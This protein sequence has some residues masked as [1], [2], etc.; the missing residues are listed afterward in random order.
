MR[1]FVGLCL[2]ITGLSIGAY[3]HYPGPAHREASLVELTEIVTGAIHS[4]SEQ[5]ALDRAAGA[6]TLD[7]ATLQ[8]AIAKPR[9]KKSNRIARF[10]NSKLLTADLA[11]KTSAAEQ[12]KL[13][14]PATRVKATQAAKQRVIAIKEPPKL[15]RARTASPVLATGWRTAV[16]R[17]ETAPVK[18]GKRTTTLTPKTYAERWKLAK[19]LQSE[20]KRVGCYWGK[21]DGVWGKGS[22]WAIADF[23]RSVN[24]TLP[25]KDPD[26]ILLQLVASHSNK[27]CGRKNDTTQIAAR[28][29]PQP[30]AISRWQARV[31][32]AETPSRRSN[33][34]DAGRVVT[35]ALQ[36]TAAARPSTSRQAVA[37]KRPPPL[38]GRMAI[39]AAN[40]PL[41]LKAPPTRITRQ[42]ATQPHPNRT[43]E[44]RDNNVRITALPTPQPDLGTEGQSAAVDAGDASNEAARSQQ[45]NPYVAKKR[46]A[47]KV[48][49]ARAM[50]KAA[51][52]K[53]KRRRA[54]NR[55]YRRRSVQSFFM[56]PLGRR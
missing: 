49:R 33:R 5:P 42:L 44:H 2:L 41:E 16:V 22:K 24:A 12:P 34:V 52:R 46:S 3:S 7:Q 36:Q 23:M 51:L 27:I 47:A 8:G 15:V 11:A 18:A 35:G 56:H 55:Y 25:T 29:K 54:R 26:Y 9:T 10:A 19:A 40:R 4:R 17:V 45:V 37:A 28:S 31:A 21:I 13:V 48:K 1:G 38:P 32:R 50:R 20:L 14:A 43:G 6:G 30:V 39:G 53:K